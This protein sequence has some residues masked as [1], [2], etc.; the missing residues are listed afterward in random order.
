MKKMAAPMMN[1]PEDMIVVQMPKI[2]LDQLI[3]ILVQ[4]RDSAEADIATQ[5]EQIAPENMS[6]SDK[7]AS[8]IM[9]ME[10]ARR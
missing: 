10:K 1:K 9:S 2:A 3:D 6:E 4:A 5:E 8:E 7:L